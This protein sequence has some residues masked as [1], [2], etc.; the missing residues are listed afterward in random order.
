MDSL[1]DSAVARMSPL[2][3]KRY[4][5]GERLSIPREQPLKSSLSEAKQLPNRVSVRGHTFALRSMSAS[6]LA[7]RVLLVGDAPSG[8][9]IDQL[10]FVAAAALADDVSKAPYRDHLV[11]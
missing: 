10:E 2:F 5:A 11:H 3:D 8:F 6:M 7:C 9:D 4:A 1:A